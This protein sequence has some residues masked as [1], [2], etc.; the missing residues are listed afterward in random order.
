MEGFKTILGTEEYSIYRST[1]I[2]EVSPMNWPLAYMK[3]ANKMMRLIIKSSIQDYFNKNRNIL[4][5]QI[6]QEYLNNKK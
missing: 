4:Q 1:R 5:A 6:A 3:V 2:K